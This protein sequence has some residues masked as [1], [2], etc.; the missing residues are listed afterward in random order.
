MS[1]MTLQKYIKIV[2]IT[3]KIQVIFLPLP[4][5]KYYKNYFLYDLML[6]YFNQLNHFLDWIYVKLSSFSY[7]SSSNDMS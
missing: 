2:K 5:Y 4:V 1:F 7:A 6:I 3:K